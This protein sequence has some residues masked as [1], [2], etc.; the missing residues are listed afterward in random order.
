MNAVLILFVVLLCSPSPARAAEG[1][2]LTP[3]DY[4]AM[5][6]L[7]DPD[8]SPDGKRIAYVVTTAD[9]DRSYYN[10]DIRI[11]DLDGKREVQL[12][13]SDRSDRMPRWSP[14]G[15]A[16]AF[17]SD[18]SGPAQI[19]LVDPNGGEA[20]PLTTV[21]GSVDS[22]RWSPSGDAIAFTE[23]PRHSL[24]KEKLA[25]KDD[26]EVVGANPSRTELHIVDVKSGEEKP[27]MRGEFSIVDFD[28]SPDGKTLAVARGGNDTADGYFT[29]D[30]Y[31]VNRGGD[32]L[33]PLV[34][35][36]GI[37][38]HPHFSPD[39]SKLAFATG[40]GLTTWNQPALVAVVPVS[41]GT[42]ALR[43]TAYGRNVDDFTWSPDGK[44]I[45]FAGPL[46]LSG[47]LFSVSDQGQLQQ[48]S[49]VDGVIHD[50]SF[51]F[52]HQ[53]VAFVYETLNAPPE[54]FVSDLAS[55]QPRQLTNVNES[56]R[57]RALGETRV[58]RWKN[59]KDGKTIEG[60]LTLPIGY[61]KGKR[62]PLL[63]FVHG[64]PASNFDLK[65]TGYL[66]S[67]YP[68]QVFAAK[69]FAMLR[70]N[71]RGTGSYP[72]EF[73][74][75]DQAD[76]GGMDF[77]DIQSGID[78]LIEQGI[79]DPQ[80]LGM[81]GWSYGGFMTSWAIGHTDRFRAV[82]IGAPVVD[83]FSFHGTTDIS[84]FTPTYFGALPYRARSLYEAHSPMTFIANART[85]ALIQQ[86]TADDRVPLSQGEML[87]RAL[88]ELHVPSMMVKYP[89][90]PHVPREP[91]QRIDVA[92]RNVWWFEKWING[93]KQT[94]ED[95]WGLEPDE[96]AK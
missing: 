93:V 96:A 18:R 5:T 7:S 39:G 52:A 76:W 81:M 11:I 61:E 2:P 58:V 90:S 48:L 79:A 26:A 83:L 91:N 38:V 25:R 30:I 6:T 60:L 51:D 44:Q 43:T 41:G 85:P 19:Y 78:A 13:T 31:L 56:Y 59:S 74:Q 77:I 53:K 75:S 36:P 28:F 15:N 71:P 73:R 46:D 68:S 92:M 21:H 69:G 40:N 72:L 57:G 33:R 37:D 20:R 1:R 89:R 10:A 64:G 70:P 95:Y 9:L 86:G 24:S 27:V 16:I 29:T 23:F 32:G 14:D 3:R 65:F 17:V 50:A 47:Q 67:L 55:F 54:L 35:R 82:S 22:F 12:A 4:A 84:G 45:W 80:K 62:Y 88:Q 8:I 42:P 63:T 34:V 66:G 87:Y 49:H 94:Y